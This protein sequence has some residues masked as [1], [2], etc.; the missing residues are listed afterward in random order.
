MTSGRTLEDIRHHFETTPQRVVSLVPSYTESMFDLG[1]GAHVVGATDYCVHPQGG[2]INIPRVGGP[3]TPRIEDILRLAPDLVL[4]NQ[5]ENTLGDV[6]AIEKAGVP[7]WVS[8]PQSVQDALDVL[9]GIVDLYHDQT[10]SLRV[11]YLEDHCDWAR[12]AVEGLPGKRYFCPIWTGTTPDGEPWWMTFNE[13]T[14]SSDL[15]AL[16]GGI[17][18]FSGRQRQYPLMAD[19]GKAAAEPG[20]DRDTRYP[21]VNLAEII[22]ADPEIIFLPNEP[23]DFDQESSEKLI[24]LLAE[25]TAVRS[26]RVYL[27]DGS[28]LTWYGTRLGLALADLPQYF[29]M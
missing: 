28:Y 1:F 27:V 7:V 26:G 21:C 22:A 24:D 29:T 6:E 5:E 12:M 20:L 11:R 8:F 14:Y 3:K 15:L 23:F 13:Q 2:L 9:W 16:F 17:N 19:L 10:A 18:G 25:T 4:A